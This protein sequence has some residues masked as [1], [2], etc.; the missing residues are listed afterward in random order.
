MLPEL[1]HIDPR[2]LRLPAS[3]RDGVDPLKLHHQIRKFGDSIE[4][5]PPVWGYESADGYIVVYN[6]V[7]RATRIAKLSPG[8]DVPVL[9]IGRLKRNYAGATTIGDLI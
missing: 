8:T 7:T 1:R 6:G 5:M 2:V 3:R 9:V 4:G